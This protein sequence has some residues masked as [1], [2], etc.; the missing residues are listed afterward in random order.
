MI[1]IL[2]SLILVGFMIMPISAQ[3]DGDFQFWD[4]TSLEGKLFQNV[5][6]KAEQELRFGSGVDYLYYHHT[7]LSFLWQTK[8]KWLIVGSAYRQVFE[9]KNSQWKKENRPYLAIVLKRNIGQLNI[10]SRNRLERRF[11]DASS[12]RYRNQVS[13]KHSG[14]RFQPYVADEFFIEHGNLSRNRLSSGFS[15]TVTKNI[16][17][18]LYY[19]WQTSKKENVWVD[20]HITSIKVKLEF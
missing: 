5:K 17:P 14:K 19:M 12:W 2:L 10:E 8:H 13:L 11:K 4:T 18:E 16:K 6:A 3:K 20:F 15:F 7:D 1:K 9:L